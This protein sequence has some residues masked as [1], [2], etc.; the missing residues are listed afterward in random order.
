MGL[1]C[2]LTTLSKHCLSKEERGG[3]TRGK[4]KRRE[5]EQERYVAERKPKQGVSMTL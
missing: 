3:D 2:V 4:S 5:E 1:F